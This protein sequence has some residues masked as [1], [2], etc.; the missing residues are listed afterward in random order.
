MCDRII[1]RADG[2]K[3][4]G[5][6][7][8]MRCLSIADAAVRMGKKCLFLTAS[9][10]FLKTIE[11][12]GHEAEVLHSDFRDLESEDVERIFRKYHP[13]RFFVDSYYATA[14][15]LGNIHRLCKKHGC[16]LIFLD[17]VQAFPYP[18]DV[19]VNYN[20]YASEGE[21][22][23]SYRDLYRN[24]YRDLYR[25]KDLP[26]NDSAVLP[27][28]LLGTE[29]APLRAEFMNLPKR[30]VRREAKHILVSTGGADTEHLTVSL[31][32][33]AGTVK[34]QE[35]A[36]L[37][38]HFVVGAMNPDRE[39]IRRMAEGFANI[40]IH[41]NVTEMAELMQSCDMAISAAGSTLYELCATQTPTVTYVLADNQRAGAAGF[42]DL[43]IME[44]CGDV[45]KLGR[46]ELARLLVCEVVSLAKDYQKRMKIAAKMRDV[47]DGKGA[48]R[49]IYE[50][51]REIETENGFG[52]T[53]E[54]VFPHN[55]R[56]CRERDGGIC[57]V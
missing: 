43:G 35:D 46:K 29:Y 53:G 31:A 2:N 47:V 6:G 49:I 38:F 20:I 5:A 50:S 40:V 25:D 15:Y 7:H 10:D 55:G 48:E 42:C 16:T 9:A 12:H 18:C 44:N 57:G 21:Y 34:F 45:R 56:S 14:A 27:R 41:E 13:E 22:R 36:G 19:L 11:A 8:V 23:N 1:F 28:L 54:R 51:G 37:T 17:D 24:L 26:E 33:A 52:E 30:I 32:E 3:Y 39:L 4:V